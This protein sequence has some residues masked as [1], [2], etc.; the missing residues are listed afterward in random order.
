MRNKITLIFSVL[1]LS[2]AMVA[3]TFGQ[4]VYGR[5]EG[6]MKDTNGAVIPGVTITVKSVGT[7]AGYNRTLTTD[8]Q[9][10]FIIPNVPP[11]NY[12]V[13]TTKDGFQSE[14]VG[15]T[16][17]LDQ[18]ASINLS[19]KAG[20]GN[21]GDVTVTGD[22]DAVTIDPT[23]SKIQTNLTQNL[24]NALPKGT[25]FTSLL[26]AAP[27][28]RGEGLAGGFQI[29]GASGSENVWVI[30]GQ[31]VTN[32]RTGVLNSNNNLPFEMIQEVQ[33]KSNG[34]EAEYGGATGGVITVATQGGNNEWHGNFGV[35]WRPQ[36]FQ[37]GLN[38]ILNRWG[39]GV[40]QY[41]LFRMTKDGGLASYPV[42]KINGPIVKDRLWFSTVYAPQMFNYT[43]DPHFYTSANPNTRVDTGSQRF[44]AKQTTQEA[45][46]RIDAQPSN[47]V[48]AYATYL[49]NPISVKGRF[50]ASSYGLTNPTSVSLPS[51]MVSAND[52]MATQGGR[53]N[54]SGI[55]GQITWTPTS[56]FVINAHAGQT[57]LNEKLGSYGIPNQTRYIC[58]SASIFAPST[59]TAPGG[60]LITTAMAGCGLNFSNM[61]SNFQ[62]AYDVSRRTLVDADASYVGVD[63]G[64][65][66]NFKWGWQYNHISNKTDQGYRDTGVMVLYYGRD[67]ADLG[68]TISLPDAVGCGYLQRFAT[69]GKASSASNALFV[70]DSW[71]IAKRLT[72]NLGVRFDAENVPSFN[73]SNPGIKFGWGDKIAPRLGVAFDV[74]GNGKTKIFA[75]YGWFYDRFKYELP[76]GSFGGDFYRRDFFDITMARGTL[77]TAYTFANVLGSHPDPIAGNCPGDGIPIYPPGY[78][79][80]NVDFRVPSNGGLGLFAGGAVDP[81]LKAARQSEYTFGAQHEFFRNWIVSGRFT[82]KQVDHAVEDTG[83]L[84][85]TGSEAYII[86]N[87]G[88]GLACDTAKGFGFPCTK[89]V[90]RYDALE[91]RADKRFENHWFFN[92]SY[93]WSRLF[94]N[95]S[96]LASSDEG[97]RTSPNVD[98]NFD[99]PYIEYTLS[100]KSNAGRLPTDRPHVFKAYGG[101]E[102]EWSKTNTTAASFYTTAQSG[103]PLSTQANFIFSTTPIYIYGRGDLGRSAPIYSTDLNIDHRYKFGRDNR[104]TVQPYINIINLFDRRSMTSKVGTITSSTISGSV[105]TSGGCPVGR[106]TDFDTIQQVLFSGSGELTGYFNNWLNA[107]P[108]ARTYNTYKI[109]NGWT[110]PR[111]VRFGIRLFF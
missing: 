94:G 34:F 32:F 79:S 58:H 73:P 88:E 22:T 10:Y 60:T 14:T 92:A 83:L 21:V 46:F 101:Y 103:A 102:F 87:P 61:P 72:L 86:A 104:V 15:V 70:Q 19:L 33:I 2:F 24:F 68:Y 82:H 93:T 8:G 17:A 48:R 38:P 36:R 31:E 56:R 106:C 9:G 69:R 81:N 27:N 107:N 20:G 43:T 35:S 37:G 95:Y 53:T 57:F 85:A 45:F 4:A 16:V 100:G 71:T 78:S 67:C 7:T 64:G 98:R 91:I 59:G 63:L 55:N 80:C 40:G 51:G 28:V 23:D 13:T 110:A 50:I 84:T 109:A 1:V 97:G 108:T 6:V 54:S 44:R 41:E 30:D 99:L 5:I 75:N 3:S 47:K 65:R 29:D 42:A 26:K 76:R 105:L 77:Y 11:G 49:W 62:I 39:T 52:F 90:R 111:E 89:A 96:G 12:S 66:H 74:F 25:T 18:A